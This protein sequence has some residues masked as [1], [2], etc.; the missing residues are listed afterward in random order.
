MK[1]SVLTDYVDLLKTGARLCVLPVPRLLLEQPIN[2]PTN[3]T[4]YPQGSIDIAEL[5]VVSW[6]Q[7]EFEEVVRT[8]GGS[9]PWTQSAATQIFSDEFLAHSLIAFPIRLNWEHFLDPPDHEYHKD[10]IREASE[11]AETAL[12]I[13]RYEFCRLDLPDT[14]P[15][16]AGT[17]SGGNPFSCAL[18]YDL[19]D[20]ESYVI[21]GQTVTHQLVAGLGLE[22]PGS[23]TSQE[24]K[25]GEVGNIVR[26]ALGLF[27][28][29]LEAS[30]LTSKFVQAMSLLEFLGNPNPNARLGMKKARP[31]I[32][33]HAA[34]DKASYESVSHDIKRLSDEN[35][36][37]TAIVHKGERFENIIAGKA[38]QAALFRRLQG[39][40][41]KIIF[42][43]IELSDASWSAVEEFRRAKMV[44]LG[45]ISDE[46]E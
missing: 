23:L 29:S 41:G 39:Y 37:R 22:L 46:A 9:L 35:S 14:L 32:A 10:V 44:R 17:L 34:R 4:L 5:R 31:Q 15:G 28:A 3:Y 45:I 18:F 38:D 6:P 40:I 2:V 26:M 43:L 21:G 42:D 30:S 7:R 36:L 33:V 19:S 11:R 8:G 25:N 16:R 13:I 27:S 12:D 20:H 24:I 1:C